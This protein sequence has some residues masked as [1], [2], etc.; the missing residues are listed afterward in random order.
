MKKNQKL[1]GIIAMVAL[2]G[3]SM[4][5]CDDG[6]A[7]GFL[8]E[9]LNLSGEVWMIDWSYSGSEQRF[10]GNL[11]VTSDLGGNGAITNGQLNFS[12]GIPFPLGS[13]N[14]LWLMEVIE[15][16]YTNINISNTSVRGAVLDLPLSRMWVSESDTHFVEESVFY[17]YVDR[18]VSVT[19]DGG[20]ET[21]E[22]VTYTITNL[23]LN[24]R[25]G[26]NAV[27]YK[28]E[29]RLSGGQW[30]L[31]VNVSLNNP[32]HLRWVLMS[33][34]TG[35]INTYSEANKNPARSFFKR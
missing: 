20:T 34:F 26:W 4:A 10:T 9:T 1:L 6:G 24:L 32:S 13:I 5:A 12:I 3:L 23:N 2:I 31:T 29:E 7:G 8:G 14:N 17:I 27:H 16:L 18:D 22:D 33:G 30:T 25:Q 35:S 28:V 21:D 11:P 19:G 15:D